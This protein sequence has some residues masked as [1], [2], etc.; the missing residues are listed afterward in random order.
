MILEAIL[1]SPH[2]TEQLRFRHSTFSVASDMILD[3]VDRAAS[4]EFYSVDPELGP[5][6]VPTF[7]ETCQDDITRTFAIALDE[8]TA[9]ALAG[10]E[11]ESEGKL[12]VRAGLILKEIQSRYDEFR[13]DSL[14]GIE[15]R[16]LISAVNEYIFE[17]TRIVLFGASETGKTSIFQFASTGSVVTNYSKTTKTN[18]V[19]KLNE[20][21]Q[22]LEKR[23][24][25]PQ[26]EWFQIANHLL[27]L[28][29][30][31]GG[32]QY[33]N[34]WKSY[35]SR[36]DVAAL[37]V[38]STEDGIVEGKK[39]LTEFENILPDHVIAIAN[40]Q[41]LEDAIPP[42]IVARFLGIETHGMV[43]IDVDRH[44]ILRDMLKTSA[45]TDYQRY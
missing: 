2:D 33:R 29:D 11:A 40:F 39:L 38:R 21:R 30:L 13:Y 25:G 12:R 34:S 27:M 22:I 17:H 42:P 28:Y 16:D 23:V 7:T 20:Y 19:P 24:T 5:L 9:I 6:R 32:K 14:S 37:V 43:A 35:L 26:D 15:K 8:N 45:V 18:V 36:A 4:A 31:P 3:L 10:D 41:D 1:L 44:D